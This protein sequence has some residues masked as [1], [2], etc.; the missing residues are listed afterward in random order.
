MFHSIARAGAQTI[1]RG[2]IIFDK[3]VMPIFDVHLKPKMKR[4]ERKYTKVSLLSFL[5]LFQRL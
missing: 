5:R 1:A 2:K 4:F 3:R